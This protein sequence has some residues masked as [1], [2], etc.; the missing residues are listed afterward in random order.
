MK[1]N[2]IPSSGRPWSRSTPQASSAH[3][4][5]QLVPNRMG[6]SICF[7]SN[8]LHVAPTVSS[9][10]IWRGH[11]SVATISYP[12]TIFITV[13]VAPL[14]ICNWKAI[15]IKVVSEPWLGKPPYLIR[16]VHFFHVLYPRPVVPFKSP[17]HRSTHFRFLIKRSNVRGGTT[18][19]ISKAL[20]N[21]TA[22]WSRFLKHVQQWNIIYN[23]TW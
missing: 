2:I 9:W 10:E 13:W 3:L 14:W 1:K 4:L 12:F 20:R 6:L 7:S 21:T 23:E 11:P 8:C 22:F 18:I 16:R 19:W 17:D 5:G 15:I